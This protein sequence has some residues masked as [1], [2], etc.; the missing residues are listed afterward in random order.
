MKK[1][2]AGDGEEAEGDGDGA[3][4][5]EDCSLDFQPLVKLPEMDTK[6][7]EEE[8]DVRLKM[9]AKLF[10]FD[11]GSGEWKERGLGEVK[12]LEHKETKK[13]RLLMR[14]EKTHKIC[15]N[16]YVNS[17][18]SLQENMGS[19]RSWVWNAVDY[20]DGDRDE[21]VLAIRFKDSDSAEEFK[22]EY[23]VAR[24]F[25]KELLAKEDT[26]ED[27]KNEE[28]SEAKPENGET[29]TASS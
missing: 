9:R 18:V 1:V 5:E 12:I 10:R 24:E 19:D 7:G 22:K 27:K 8:E 13:I 26:G 28:E 4:G 25:M 14:R 6:T 29:T 23:E 2:V 21:C 3:A 17:E 11:K 15:L 20:A 16:H